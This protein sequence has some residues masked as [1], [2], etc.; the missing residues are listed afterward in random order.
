MLASVLVVEDVWIRIGV[1]LT[2]ITWT[3]GKF[4]ALFSTEMSRGL[5]YGGVFWLKVSL[6]P[7]FRCICIVAIPDFAWD[8]VFMLS[9]SPWQFYSPVPFCYCVGGWFEESGIVDV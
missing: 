4:L 5:K 1:P 2:G 7:L 3:G 8:C 6:L 9:T